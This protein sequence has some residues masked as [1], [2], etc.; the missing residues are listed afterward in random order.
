MKICIFQFDI[1]WLDPQAN[2]SIIK[3]QLGSLEKD[4]DLIVLPEMFL[5]GFCMKPALSAVL[6]SGNEIEEL[7]ELAKEFSIGI[8]GSLAIKEDGKYYNRVFLLSE[9]GII[10]RYDKQYLFSLSGENDVFDSKYDTN[11]MKFNGWNI[12]PQVC[13][14]L[15]FP[16]NVRALKAPD[17]LIYMANWPMPRIHHWKAL[18]TARAIENQCFVIGCNRTGKDENDWEYPG[19]SAII[20][21]DGTI[22]EM[23]EDENVKVVLLSLEENK[24]YRA[25]YRFLDDKKL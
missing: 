3:N 18:L 10:G 17:L 4:V 6:E 9:K 5:S 14:D 1:S 25:K 19:N 12:L 13:Y 16:E 15:R 21:A 7:I 22:I 23:E 24:N 8:I 20:N 2:L 11:V